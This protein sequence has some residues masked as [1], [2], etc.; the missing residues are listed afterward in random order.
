MMLTLSLSKI[1]AMTM[2]SRKLSFLDYKIHLYQVDT[3]FTTTLS[4]RIW[5]FPGS[6]STPTFSVGPSNRKDHVV[7]DADGAILIDELGRSSHFFKF[8]FSTYK[9]KG[10]DSQSHYHL[11]IQEWRGVKT[12][13][14]LNCSNSAITFPRSRLF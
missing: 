13:L 1:M 9:E 10:L 4:Y 11:T 12:L 5:R 8:S 6:N 2:I 14:R 3:T 7:I